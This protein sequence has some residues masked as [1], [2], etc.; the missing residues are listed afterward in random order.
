M[1]E[2]HRQSN[3][4]LVMVTHDHAL[5]ARAQRQVVLKDGMVISDTLNSNS[6]DFTNDQ[7]DNPDQI[8]E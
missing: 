5:A 1:T 7:T 3:V 2:L 6:A 4:T 8:A